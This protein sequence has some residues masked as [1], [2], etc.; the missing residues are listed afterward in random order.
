[1]LPVA[2]LTLA[3]VVAPPPAIQLERLARLYH[4]YELP[5]PPKD[6]KLVRYAPSSGAFPAPSPRVGFDVSRRT[7]RFFYRVLFG[8]ETD[9]VGQQG[10]TAIDPDP[11]TLAAAEVNLPTTIQFYFRGWHELAAAVYAKGGNW[12]G[13]D[14]ERTLAVYAMVYWRKQLANPT[15]DRAKIARRLALVFQGEPTVF[16]ENDRE[17][18]DHLLLSLSPSKAKPGS[19]EADIDELLDA[20][21]VV[22]GGSPSTDRRYTVIVT[23]GFDAV[24]VLIDHL[25]DVRLTRTQLFAFL[26]RW[27][28][29]R[30]YRIRDFASDALAGLLHDGDSGTADGMVRAADARRWWA[31]VQKM[32]EETFAVARVLKSKADDPSPNPH[33]LMLI[34]RKYPER[35]PE[36]FQKLLTDHPTMVLDELAATVA[37]SPLPKETKR[38]LFTEATDTKNESWQRVGREQLKAL[39]AKK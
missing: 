22:H 36:V 14:P 26:P 5:L 25:N 35:L 19:A 4:A 8:C 39:D 34:E 29:V 11:K 27:S 33:L 32:S 3:V 17:F 13:E 24:P 37:E 20:V 10:L 23:R 9:T 6:A 2:A 16:L 18:Y 15:V 30:D 12:K 31:E 21:E 38:K 1:M 28:W 7:D